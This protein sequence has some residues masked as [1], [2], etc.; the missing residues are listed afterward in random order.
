MLALTLPL[1]LFRVTSASQQ[2][3]KGARSL[4]SS[5][6]MLSSASTPK[7]CSPRTASSSTQAKGNG[8][9]SRQPSSHPPSLHSEREE[10]AATRR[11]LEVQLQLLERKLE[12]LHRSKDCTRE[13]SNSSARTSSTN[14]CP[15][16]ASA[17]LQAH[18]SDEGKAS[19]V[20][21]AFSTSV[22]RPGP[23]FRRDPNLFKKLVQHIKE[24]RL[25][26]RDSTAIPEPALA[27]HP[28][29]PLYCTEIQ[30]GLDKMT[31]SYA[32][33]DPADHG[34]F[35]PSWSECCS[36]REYES[37]SPVLLCEK[38]RSLSWSVENVDDD[39]YLT[40]DIYGDGKLQERIAYKFRKLRHRHLTSLL[41]I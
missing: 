34:D 41:V 8:F 39:Q 3:Q 11:R 5:P 12:L 2:Q 21:S 7:Q 22:H 36:Q 35:P 23:N 24:K 13:T 9:H 4:S 26:A 18:A 37:K 31:C 16:A 25:A 29:S 17:S 27:K 1:S 15:Q 32:E 40:Q 19:A 14:A 30:H 20:P 10:R 28:G 38:P 33:R 6:T